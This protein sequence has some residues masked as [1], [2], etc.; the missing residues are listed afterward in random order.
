MLPLASP[1]LQATVPP[2]KQTLE[3]EER[4][5]WP[6]AIVPRQHLWIRLLSKIWGS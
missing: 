5:V 3:R 2:R 1:H 6:V 4:K